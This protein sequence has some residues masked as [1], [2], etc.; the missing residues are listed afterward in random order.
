MDHMRAAIA[1]AVGDLLGLDGVN[2][3]SVL[4]GSASRRRRRCVTS[5]GPARGGSGTKGVGAVVWAQGRAAHV[6][7]EMREFIGLCGA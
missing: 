1:S 7:A 2:E 6:P 5:G 4:W 3:P